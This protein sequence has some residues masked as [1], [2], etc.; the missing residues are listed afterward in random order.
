MLHY[1][2]IP[3]TTNGSGAATV[4]SSAFCGLVHALIYMPGSS[5]IDT[6]AT[7]TVT[8]DATGIA[9]WAKSSAGTSTLNVLPRGATVGV[10][11]TALVYAGTDPVADRIAV[12][13]RVKV[14]IASG[15]STKSGAI[16]VVWD[17][18]A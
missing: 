9:I 15:G 14:V 18:C 7:V 17:D 13:S 12:V 3:I 2:R 1:E 4:Y 16:G 5:G 10:T 11:N 6:G 8:E